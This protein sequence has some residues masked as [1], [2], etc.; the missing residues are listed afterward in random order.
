MPMYLTLL[1]KA[2]F[3]QI[4]MTSGMEVLWTQIQ[5]DGLFPNSHTSCS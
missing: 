4:W 1:Q 3:L 2:A 5:G